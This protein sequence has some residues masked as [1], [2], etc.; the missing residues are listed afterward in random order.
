MSCDC[1]YNTAL[2]SRRQNKTWTQN[3]NNN[4]NQPWHPFTKS[5][6]AP[7]TVQL[8]SNPPSNTL[9]RWQQST[10]SWVLPLASPQWRDSVCTLEPPPLR[11]CVVSTVYRGHG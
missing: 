11:P 6:H 3:I 5:W 10:S 8:I 4:N 1:N 2:Q 9:R 7:G